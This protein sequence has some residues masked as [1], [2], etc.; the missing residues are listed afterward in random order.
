MK[1]L[2]ILDVPYLRK[3]YQ[4]INYFSVEKVAFPP[5]ELKDLQTLNKSNNLG[6][7]GDYSTPSSIKVKK[8]RAGIARS[9]FREDKRK[10]ISRLILPFRTNF[11]NFPLQFTV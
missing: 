10:S 5:K 3:I 9:V 6:T 4:N 1:H 8:Y 2:I 11:D 7:L